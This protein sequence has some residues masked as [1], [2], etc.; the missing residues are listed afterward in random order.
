MVMSG[1][2]NTW[3]RN[4][5]INVSSSDTTVS[6]DGD[7]EAGDEKIWC[8]VIFKIRDDGTTEII[9]KGKYCDKIFRYD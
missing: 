6:A 4:R 9:Y 7:A 8:R 3:S 1:S 2:R 5:N